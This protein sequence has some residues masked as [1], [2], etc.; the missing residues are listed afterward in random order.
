MK[1]NVDAILTVNYCNFKNNSHSRDFI[2]CRAMRATSI[3]V[4]SENIVTIG[5]IRMNGIR[6]VLL[7]H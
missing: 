2:L 4:F 7:V 5:V 1:H 3:P 6:S